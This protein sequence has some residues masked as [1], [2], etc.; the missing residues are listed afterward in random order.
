M[1]DEY[2]DMVEQYFELQ[3]ERFYRGEILKDCHPELS[4]QTGVTP[5]SIE[6][7]RDHGELLKTIPD[8]QKPM[9]PHP[10]EF[11][12]KWRFFWPIGERPAEVRDDLPKTIPEE[13]PEWEEKMDSWGNHMVGAAEAAVRMCALGMGIAEDTF[14]SRMNQGAH[15]LAPTASDL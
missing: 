4:Y 13:F 9:S 10:P 1:N 2:I 12:A 14:S 3:G 5:Q 15:L 6:K 11:D 7:A 8:E